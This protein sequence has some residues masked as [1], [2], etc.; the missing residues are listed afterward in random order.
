MRQTLGPAAALTLDRPFTDE[1]GDDRRQAAAAGFPARL[2]NSGRRT[3]PRQR[4]LLSML[5]VDPDTGAIIPCRAEN[6]SDKGARLKLSELRFIPPTF[7]LIAVTSGLAYHATTIW[8]R[9]DQ[10]GIFAGEPV[11]LSDPTSLVERK[12]AKIW[13]SRR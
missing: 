4:V 11:E 10:I 9:H 8:R 3:S 1:S 7:W 2:A 13:I 12:L 5:I 6:V